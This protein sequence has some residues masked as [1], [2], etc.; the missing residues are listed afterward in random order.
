MSGV[1]PGDLALQPL[2]VLR[3][4]H[5]REDL[6]A[7]PGEPP[8][9][10]LPDPARRAGDDDRAALLRSSAAI[11]PDSVMRAVACEPGRALCAES[12]PDH[13]YAVATTP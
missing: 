1:T 13:R 2:A 7:E 4:A 6:E 8:R 9:A 10:R 3:L 12:L 5:A 11:A